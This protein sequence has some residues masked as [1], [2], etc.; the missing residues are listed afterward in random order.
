MKK[1]NKNNKKNERFI[2]FLNMQSLFGGTNGELL[3]SLM[4]TFNKK[5]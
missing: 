3:Q 2:K 4:K 1:E 5:K